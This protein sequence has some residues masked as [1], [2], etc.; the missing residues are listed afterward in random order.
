MDALKISSEDVHTENMSIEKF[1]RYGHPL[2]ERY[3][4][5]EMSF[6]WSPQNKF[7]T[8]RKLWLAL[9][10]GERELGLDITED[11]LEEMRNHLYDIDFA[12]AEE[13][14]KKF[15]HDVMAVSLYVIY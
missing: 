2:V 10:E 6:I 9:A 15:R 8:W 11:Q 4:S 1:K 12:K 14:E 5:D 3:A 7:S 13:Y